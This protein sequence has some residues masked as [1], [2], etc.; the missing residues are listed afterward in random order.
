[1]LHGL[2]MAG[3][4]L[5]VPELPGFNSLCNDIDDEVLNDLSSSF[6]DGFDALDI[7]MCEP[8][9]FSEHTTRPDPT[10]NFFC[11]RFDD[12]VVTSP[13]AVLAPI[14]P[15][16][17]QRQPTKERFDELL[18]RALTAGDSETGQ[19][20]A[21]NTAAMD[22]AM[23]TENNSV[24]PAAEPSIADGLLMRNPLRSPLSRGASREVIRLPPPRSDTPERDAS[25]PASSTYSSSPTSPQFPEEYFGRSGSASP[26]SPSRMNLTVRRRLKGA[27]TNP[28]HAA[29]RNH[30]CPHCSSRFLCK[31]KLDR[32]MLTHTGVKPFGCYCGKRFNQKSA[33][34]NHTRRHLKKREVPNFEQVE[35]YGLNG[36]SLD[37]LMG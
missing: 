10:A 16:T 17:L 27:S 19:T 29:G 5:D 6:C 18:R 7:D 35:Q 37:E 20:G 36:F 31:S 23:D 15:P 28:K 11:A 14:R 9:R 21:D 4:M 2:P 26:T 25:S 1:M 13:Q 33:L 32:H 34:K 24:K 3:G 30:I 12:N 22:T 8:F